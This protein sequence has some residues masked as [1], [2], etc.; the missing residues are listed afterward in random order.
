MVPHPRFKLACGLIR[1]VISLT[2][3]QW[4]IPYPIKLNI[5][6]RRRV[7]AILFTFYETQNS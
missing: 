4:L 1:Q 5:K 6:I 2:Y 7:V 3:F